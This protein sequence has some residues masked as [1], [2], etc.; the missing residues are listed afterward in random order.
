MPGPDSQH[1]LELES[2]DDLSAHKTTIFVDKITLKIMIVMHLT[3]VT[4]FVRGCEKQIVW[5]N[6]IPLFK[7][8]RLLVE[9]SLMRLTVNH[10]FD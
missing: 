1:T 8:L 6:S 5:T 10:A 4:C 9:E 2:F 7:R 3:F